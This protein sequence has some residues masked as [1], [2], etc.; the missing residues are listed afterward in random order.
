MDRQIIG[1]LKP[2]LAQDLH[3]SEIDY[4][5]IVFF[6][7]LAYAAGYVGMGR[8]MD[9]SGSGSA[10]PSPSSSGASPRPAHGLA[11][12]VFGFGL[13][14]F[15]LGI[16]EGGNFP[17][18]IKTVATG[19]RSRSGPSPPASSTPGSNV[20]ALL[21]PLLVPWIATAWGWR[22]AFFATGAD[23]LHLAGL[24]AASSIATPEEHPRLSRDELAYI[25]SD[26]DIP[27]ENDP[28]AAAARL[29]RDLGVH[30]R[31]V[32]DRSR[33]GGSTCSGCR[34]SCTSRTAST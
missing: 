23:R 24:L 4:G 10:S 15:L 5:N 13:A 27:T 33:S 25:R 21:T 30:R 16:G 34:T 22:A 1:V 2:V 19:S 6:F 20:G 32:P 17:A 12:S 3:W 9:W 14:R 29:P 7:Q 26:P 31:Q 8:L 28:L 11:R 18:A